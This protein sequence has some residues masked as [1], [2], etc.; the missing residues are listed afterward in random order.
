MS[1]TTFT[2]TEIACIIAVA[3]EADPTN[4]IPV[5]AAAVM[6]AKAYQSNPNVTQWKVVAD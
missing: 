1:I 5:A 3:A 2:T 4:L 6:K